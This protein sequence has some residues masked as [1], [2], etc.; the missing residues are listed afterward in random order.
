MNYPMPSQVEVDACL[1]ELRE[2]REKK[3]KPA[4]AKI[5]DHHRA[6]LE[7]LRATLS[8][9]KTVALDVDTARRMEEVVAPRGEEPRLLAARREAESFLD[10]IEIALEHLT[11]ALARDVF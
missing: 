10:D 5:P 11:A 9:E 3:E 6:V 8:I 7:R 1:R 2:Q 4:S